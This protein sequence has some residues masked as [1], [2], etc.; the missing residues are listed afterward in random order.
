MDVVQRGA[1]LAPQSVQR[2]TVAGP[3][4][5]NTAIFSQRHCVKTS[6]LATPHNLLA[7]SPSTGLTVHCELD[8]DR[9]NGDDQYHPR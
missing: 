6:T 1:S 5:G 9:R 2:A 4:I 7:T 3:V 8:Q